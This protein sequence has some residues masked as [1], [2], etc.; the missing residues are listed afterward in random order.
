MKEM[1]PMPV[2]AKTCC[3]AWAVIVLLFIAGHVIAQQPGIAIPEDTIEAM[4]TELSEAMAVSSS[5]RQ[6]LAL[7]RVVRGAEAAIKD[8]PSAPNRFEVMDVLFR[9]QQALFKQQATTENRQ[10]IFETC[11]MLAQAP[12]AYADLRWDADLLLSQ[13]KIARQGGDAQQRAAAL[14]ELVDRYLGT[15]VEKKAVRTALLMAVE[16]GEAG[17]IEYLDSLIAERY[18]KD[19]SMI[20]FKRDHLPSQVFGATFYAQLRDNHGGTMRFPMDSFGTTTAFLF[21]SNDKNGQANLKEIAEVLKEQ[22]EDK[23]RRLAIYSINLDEL[24]DAGESILREHGIDWP[25]LHLPGGRDSDFYK[26]YARVDPK[27]VTLSPA[28]IASLFQTG[29]NMHG[30]GFQRWLGSSKARNWVNS[31]YCSNL[32]SL[33]SGEFLILDPSGTFDHAMP[34]ELKAL[35]SGAQKG[36]LTNKRTEQ[37]VP[38]QTLRA[39]QACFTPAPK[40]YGLSYEEAL[41]GYRKAEQ[42]S[43]Q[44]IKAHP[45]APDLWL[46]RNRRM[47]ALMGLWKITMD[48][49]HL[50]DAAAEAQAALKAGCPE[51]TDA[52]ARLCLARQ[53]VHEPEADAKAIIQSLVEPEGDKPPAAPRLAAA[54]LLAME[55]GERDTYAG[56]RQTLLDQHG[57]EPVLWPLTA[58]MLDRYHRFWLYQIPFVSGWIYERRHL[59]G[60]SNLE[61]EHVRHFDLPFKTLKGETVQLPEAAKGKWAIIRLYRLDQFGV[62]RDHDKAFIDARP[63]DNIHVYDVVLSDDTQAIQDEIAK[64]KTPP[65]G[66]VHYLAADAQDRLNRQFDMQHDPRRPSLLILRPDGS[67][68]LAASTL[69]YRGMGR[70]GHIIPAYFLRQDEADV[71]AALAKGDLEEAKRIAFAHVPPGTPH[72]PEDRQSSKG[73]H[74]KPVNIANQHLR[75]RAKV[76]IAMQDWKAAQADVDMLYTE[77]VNQA[78]L[79]GMRTAELEDAEQM[80]ARIREAMKPAETSP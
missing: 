54:A 1:T 64:R 7:R 45:D 43:A 68:A 44:A 48:P 17:L 47:V 71:D 79:M 26:A 72:P 69:T 58:F 2:V 23:E 66:P 12:D 35:S 74:R 61:P 39:I 5:T 76:F 10:A 32:Q 65:V 29:G 38:E 59:H 15:S 80:R 67:V 70:H 4:R 51:G 8:N 46:V 63:I 40:R 33:A 53:A 24:A 62:H 78:S 28:G 6:K 22:P 49:R 18:A 13:V 57:S 11:Q 77:L 9:T 25:A 31:D 56:I 52:I 30:K 73:S 16:A 60:I 27:F 42:L 41:A 34:P 21:W 3:Q 37:S 20:A 75:A 19:L 14:R 55:L 50:K 36:G